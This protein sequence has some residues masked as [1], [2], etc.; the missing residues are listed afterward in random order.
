[1][2]TVLLEIFSG[3]KSLELFPP[4]KSKT[5]SSLFV[6]P[7]FP[8]SPLQVALI[9]CGATFTVAATTENVLYFWGTRFI[10][11]VARPNTRD[12]RAAE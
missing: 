8:F 12:G 1:M 6:M 7:R 2:L 11:P 5:S 10:S 9:S 4:Q 3:K